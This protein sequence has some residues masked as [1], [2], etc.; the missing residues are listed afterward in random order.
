M[1]KK[2]IEQ[3]IN[4]KVNESGMIETGIKGVQLFKITEPVRCAPAVYEPSVTAIVCGGKE[5]IVDGDRHRYDASR[6]ICC[7]MSMP[8]EA[9]APE[10]SPD[11][12]LMGVYITLNTSLMTQ[13]R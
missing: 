13:G 3:L 7:S 8:I 2:Q 4:S 5:A 1:R 11:N 10:A 6:Y 12:P 9:G